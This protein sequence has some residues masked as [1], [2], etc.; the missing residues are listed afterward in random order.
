[1]FGSMFMFRTTDAYR[2]IFI[3]YSDA[4]MGMEE[5]QQDVAHAKEQRS[6]ACARNGKLNETIA[7]IGCNPLT[8]K[9]ALSK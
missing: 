6:R 7:T 5:F 8:G 9:L 3:P 1:M 4:F 2:K